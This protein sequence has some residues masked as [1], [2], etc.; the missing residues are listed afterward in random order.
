MAMST[1]RSVSRQVDV[2]PTFSSLRGYSLVRLARS[3]KS[4]LLYRNP[5]AYSWRIAIN[6]SILD[7]RLAGM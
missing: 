7:A 5:N 4:D 2:K 6:G 1:G 3:A